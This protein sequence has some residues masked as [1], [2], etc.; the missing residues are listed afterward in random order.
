MKTIL[1]IAL[2]LG[3]VPTRPAPHEFEDGFVERT[4]A[5]VIRDNLA[6]A[7][8]SIGLNESTMQELLDHWQSPEVTDSP[9]E[10]EQLLH[11]TPSPSKTDARSRVL[12]GPHND[13]QDKNAATEPLEKDPS[14]VET[15][16]PKPEKP[17]AKPATQTDEPSS[18]ASSL[19]PEAESS[20]RNDA[21]ENSG[22]PSSKHLEP[23]IPE[24]LLA[25]LKQLGPSQIAKKIAIS[26]NGQPLQI[27]NVSA[28]A[29]PRHPFNLVV[30][31]EF[32]IPSLESAALK[33]ED[34]NFRQHNGAIRY[35]LKALGNTILVKSNVAPI[36]VRAQRHQ[37]GALSKKEAS[38]WTSISAEILRVSKLNIEN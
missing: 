29:A 3:L 10:D 27:K 25:S 37:L 18:A 23:T 1:F 33:I 30:Q 26:C 8:Y 36:I 9:T 15:S 32:E 7:E 19:E 4:F 13:S 5:I 17:A 2:T 35:A 34:R 31:F 12:I 24:E 21:L 16:L 22:S 28:A 6:T 20:I 11:K 14:D 38:N